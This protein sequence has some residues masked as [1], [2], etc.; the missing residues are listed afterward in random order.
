MK[1]GKIWEKSSQMC[2]CAQMLSR[3]QLFMTPCAVAR[4]TP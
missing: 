1:M 3:V 2:V 4:Q